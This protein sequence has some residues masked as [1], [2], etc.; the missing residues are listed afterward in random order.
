MPL[1]CSKRPSDVRKAAERLMRPSRFASGYEDHGSLRRRHADTSDVQDLVAPSKQRDWII[2][3]GSAKEC[4]AAGQII[5]AGAVI[6]LSRTAR[7]PKPDDLM[8][9]ETSPV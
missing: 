2:G 6:S 8:R 7:S 9:Y 4:F 3:L 5:D 1:V